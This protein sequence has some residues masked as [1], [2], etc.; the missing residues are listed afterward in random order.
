MI[1]FKMKKSH[2]EYNEIKSLEDNL[3][4]LDSMVQFFECPKETNDT[5]DEDIKSEIN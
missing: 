2:E 5:T 1:K 3:L 4:D